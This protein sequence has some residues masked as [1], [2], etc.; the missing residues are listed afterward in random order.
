MSKLLTPV[1]VYTAESQ[2][3][4]FGE[5][6][7]S[8]VRGLRGSRYVAYRLARNSIAGSYTQSVLGFVWD[9]VD[10]I[11]LAVIF[12][13]LR[14]GNVFETGAMHMP[15]SVFVVHGLLM[16][17]TFTSTTMQTVGL[18]R[19][20]RGL[21]T[22]QKLPPEALLLSVFFRS[23]FF[24]VFRI[25]VIIAFSVFT[26]TFSVF[27][28]VWFVLGFP[29]LILAGM[30]IG[31]FLAPFNAIYRD[32]GRFVSMV[33][34]PLRFLSPVI[35][36]LAGTRFEVTRFINP[37]WT[38]VDNLRLVATT[39]T[40]V[41]PWLLAAHLGGLFVLGLVGWFMFHVSVPILAERA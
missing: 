14:K 27:G 10:P 6:L 34:V 3:R 5:V 19:A 21:I 4:N 31:V 38:L 30:S 16:Y 15:Y 32:V 17:Q 41:E 40:L 24:S 39:N 11:V 37:F 18:L 36:P 26:G 13:F 28:L 1:Q 29:L 23:L 7:R 2:V 12:Y 22:Q 9:F 8:M 20:S 33:L 35:F 25:L